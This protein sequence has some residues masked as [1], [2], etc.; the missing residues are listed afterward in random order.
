MIVT[1]FG[2]PFHCCWLEL[3]N[4]VTLWLLFTFHQMVRTKLFWA[5]DLEMKYFV[6]VTKL[7]TLWLLFNLFIKSI[8][9]WPFLVRTKLFWAGDLVMILFVSYQIWQ[10]FN[11][12]SLIHQIHVW[13]IFPGSYKVV[14]SRWLGNEMFCGSYL[15]WYPLHFFA[16]SYQR[17]LWMTLSGWYKVCFG[18]NTL[19]KTVLVRVT[20]FGN[21]WLLLIRVTKFGNPLIVVHFSSSA[22]VVDLSW[23]VQNG[24][25]AGDL[26]MKSF[27]RVTK[28]GNPRD[29][30][31]FPVKALCKWPF[32]VGTWFVLEVIFCWRIFWLELPNLVTLWLLFTFHQMHLW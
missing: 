20:K 14:L 10:P 30:S 22:F 1:K 3:P 21:L 17:P 27:L 19:W 7:V 4:L 6:R 18:Y 15:I 11:C 8:C 23:F 24:F 31:Q 2:N 16:I 26:V 9:G 13:V 12:C 28:F 5:G 32:L 29:F 25:S